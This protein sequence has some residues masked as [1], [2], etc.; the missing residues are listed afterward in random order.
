MSKTFC[1]TSHSNTTKKT[2]CVRSTRDDKAPTKRESRHVDE[3]AAALIP[4]CV[5]TLV[6][7]TGCQSAKLLNVANFSPEAPTISISGPN[8]VR[9]GQT[10]DFSDLVT[11]LSDT[12][13]T[14]S[15][16]GILGGNQEV[17]TISSNGVYTASSSADSVSISCTSRVSPSISSSVTLSVLNPQPTM[18][19]ATI[20][21]SNDLG[22][23]VD[24]NGAGFIPQSV[25][26]VS[27]TLV[28]TEFL[29]G[30]E[31][32]ATVT[33]TGTEATVV[34]DVS[35]P[36]PGGATSNA[37]EVA[38]PPTT[39][40]HAVGCNNPY[41]NLSTGSWGTSSD[42]LYISVT[43][44]T[45]LIGTPTYKT[46]TIFWTSREAR[47]GDSVLMTGAFTEESKSAK[48]AFIPEGTTDW[49][50][51]VRESG[52]VVPA[53]QQ[54]TTGLSFIVPAQF[55]EGV[56]GFE[57][58]D[59]IAPPTYG[60]A[61]SPSIA[62]AIG[63]PSATDPLAA[64]KSVVHDCGV[65]PGETLRIFGKNF[66][67]SNRV[68]LE[69]A[70]GSSTELA[71]TKSDT[72][73]ISVEI[74]TSLVPGAYY[75]WV[76]SL[77][78]SAT[79]SPAISIGVVAPPLRTI[80]NANCSALIG[81]GNTDNTELL[82]SCLDENAPSDTPN[83]FV[84]IGIP[85][86]V[87]VL[88]K[89]V[90][91]RQ[92]EILI[93]TTP[94][95]SQFLGESPDPQPAAWFTI[96]QYSGMANI[97]IK[98]SNATYLLCGSDLTGSPVTSG[99]VL[100]DNMSFDSTPAGSNSN[101]VGMV[102]IS[103]PDVQIY[104]STF[105]SGT[106]ENLGIYFGDGVIISGNTFVNDNGSNNFESSQNIIVESNSVYSEA[107]P[108]PNGASAFDFT[109]H[110]CLNCNPSVTR[111]EYVGYNAIQNL[112]AADNQI[113]LFDGG[114][115]AYYGPVASSTADTVVLGDDPSW[116]WTGTGDLEGVSVAIVQ[117][118]GAGQQ[119]FI[120][121][122]NGRAISLE[123]PWKVMPD[124]TSVVVITASE[125]NLIVAHNLL[126]NTLGQSI[127][128][129]RS[130]DTVIEDNVL[131]NSGQGILLWGYGPYGGPE[132]YPPIMN[133]DLLRNQIE[134]GEGNFITSESIENYNYAGI[135]I[136][137]GP[138]IVVSGLMVRQNVLPSIQSIYST[139]GVNGISANVIEENH[140]KW[141]GLATPIPGFLIQDNTSE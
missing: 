107:G 83:S 1:N 141:V 140:A 63:V 6:L 52:T 68:I 76:G 120:K 29:S 104:N 66:S 98:A 21:S 24:I 126:T 112:G 40:H 71:P 127:V 64:L 48:V 79:S 10:A 139:N 23:V 67:A 85:S 18:S 4:L 46:N 117:G 125:F 5:W 130:V 20:L 38:L 100:L 57:I 59:P 121:G 137:D 124:S 122:V 33:Q 105:L 15:V 118:T 77:P 34:I 45:A 70:N 54:G 19:S 12:S 80:R 123:M 69:S 128:L 56:Y 35:N 135:G 133:T 11:G 89:G 99:H 30:S 13:V 41:V 47:P 110:F 114:A 116:I 95:D 131:I 37:I 9:S 113:I 58:V 2:H 32:R 103:G 31:L 84:Y 132:A 81:D 108:G 65:E 136:Y 22:F 106:L 78:W 53:T 8:Q 91:I 75:L 28:S 87:F 55:P 62:W 50:S 109:R 16:N 3:L 138:G 61:N 26:G 129:A 97:A 96:P 101:F 17:G 72:N 44:R 82:Q 51:S 7:V 94:S 90:T 25:V 102:A 119:S 134:V 60:L 36:D 73:S 88:T 86:G 14:W 42:A 43:N 93:G 74:P 39:L 27:G 115:G 49:Q 111:N 92:G